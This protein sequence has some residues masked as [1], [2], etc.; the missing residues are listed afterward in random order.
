MPSFGVYRG[1]LTDITDLAGAGR[2]KI[3][4]PQLG[5]SSVAA[6]VAYNCSASWQMTIGATVIVAFENGDVQYPIVI[7]QIDS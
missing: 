5:I 3:S 1:R 7:G 6:P 2:V 4:I